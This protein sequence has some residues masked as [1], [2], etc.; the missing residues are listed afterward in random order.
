MAMKA[1]FRLLIFALILI[2]STLSPQQIKADQVCV[3]QKVYPLFPEAFDKRPPLASPFMTE[4]GMDLLLA[5]TKDRK[6]VLIPVTVENGAPLLYSKRIPSLYGKDKQLEVDSGD[7]PALAKTGL[8]S[9][10]ELDEKDRITDIPVSVITHIGRPGRFSYAGFLAEDE[11]IISVLRGDNFLVKKLGLT[12]PQM[13]R[14]LFHVWNIILKEIENG[15]PRYYFTNIQFVFYNDKNL[16]LKAQGTKGWQLSIFQD[17]IQGRFDIEVR[18]D[19]S[20]EEK[21]YLRD[22]YSFL[23]AQQLA[24]LEKKLTVINFSEM[25]P[26]YIMHYGF[27]EG[28]TSY[29][30]DPIA[31]AFIFGLKSLEEIEDAFPGNIYQ[32]MTDH[33]VAQKSHNDAAQILKLHE[34]LLESHRKNDAPGVLAAEPEHIVAV[35]RGEVLFPLKADR[36]DHYREYLA[37]VEFSEYGDLMEPMV[38]VSDDATLGWLI[39]RVKITGNQLGRQGEKV[40]FDSTWAW[41]E[42]YEKREGRWFRVGEVS[43]AKPP[44]S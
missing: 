36:L 41:I 32:A 27:Y 23:A 35:S 16:F 43:N 4:D 15:H 11:D 34:D 26:Y 21:S 18:R 2:P 28:H 13:A 33:F 14:P 25:S 30:S 38:R 40:P 10:L 1:V 24:E 29:R 42:L 9:E 20:P 6:Y 31:V 5:C 8:H 19:L 37:D 22:K 3:D 44:G 12:H 7:F 17:E 39:A